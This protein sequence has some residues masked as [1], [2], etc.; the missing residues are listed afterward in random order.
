MR[1]GVLT[2]YREVNFGANLQ[3]LSTFCYLKNKGHE[4]IFVLYQTDESLYLTDKRNRNNIL[5]MREHYKF[6]DKVI[7]TQTEVCKNSDD[8]NNAINKYGLQ[9]IIV[10]SDAVLQHHPLIT[11]IKNG[12]RKPITILKVVPERLFPNPFW[13]IGIKSNIP[14]GLFSV[15]SQDSDF[16]HFG[17]KTKRL[18]SDALKRMK[19]ISVRDTW[20]KKM[21]EYISSDFVDICITPDPVFAFNQNVSDLIPSKDVILKKYNL[22]IKYALISLHNQSLSENQLDELKSKFT[23]QEIECVAFPMPSGIKF[24]HHFDKEILLPLSPIDWYALIKYSFAY[25]GSNMHPIVVSLHNAVPCYSIDHWGKT[26]FWR[27]PIHDGSSKVY[28]ILRTFGVTNCYSQLSRDH[29]D[30]S[31]SI[32]FDSIMDFP[33]KNVEQKAKTFLELYNAS[34]DKLLNALQNKEN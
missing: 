4:P 10:G 2:F 15:S 6:V 33:K 32:I 11:R 5:Q 3:A 12:S 8:I 28:D 14:M 29:T 23:S 31:S 17:N 24:K 1:I 25:I 18:M 9:A 16:S 34:M 22:P 13:G 27:R 7:E 30:V 19:Y 21:I 26:D 20:T